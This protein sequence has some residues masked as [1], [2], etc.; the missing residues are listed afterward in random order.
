MPEKRE[1]LHFV[2][3]WQKAQ[4]QDAPQGGKKGQ[5]LYTAERS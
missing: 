1:E 2:I 5:G 3:G 4:S